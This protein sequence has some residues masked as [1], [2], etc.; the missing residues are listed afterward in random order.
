MNNQE[1]IDFIKKF[2]RERIDKEIKSIDATIAS[3]MLAQDVLIKNMR[4]ALQKKVFLINQNNA[5][6]KLEDSL[7]EEQKEKSLNEFL[8]IFCENTELPEIES[9]KYF[10]SK[11]IVFEWLDCLDNDYS[12]EINTIK[13]EI[14][15]IYEVSM[16]NDI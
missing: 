10:I 1:K 5:L 13:D 4:K 9:L 16:N 8:D 3:T 15:H 12:A 6:K 2:H 7:S 14:A 11:E